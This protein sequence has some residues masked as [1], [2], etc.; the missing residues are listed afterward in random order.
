MRSC[1]SRLLPCPCYV[2]GVRYPWSCTLIYSTTLCTPGVW[3]YCGNM[4]SAM[5]MFYSVDKKLCL[6]SLYYAVL[7]CIYGCKLCFAVLCVRLSRVHTVDVYVGDIGWISKV[8][9]QFLV[10]SC[11]HPTSLHWRIF[12]SLQCSTL[13]PLMFLRRRFERFWGIKEGLLRFNQ[14][15]S[16]LTWSHMCEATEDL[17]CKPVRRFAKQPNFFLNDPVFLNSWLENSQIAC[18]FP[19]I[20]GIV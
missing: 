3:Q 2:Q 15:L 20:P 8:L 1:C 9:S 11:P 14:H 19:P 6:D 5:G 17:R 10:S 12:L 16:P 4:S 7:L 18:L 13:F